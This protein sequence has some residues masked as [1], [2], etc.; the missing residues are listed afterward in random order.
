MRKRHI[1]FA[2]IVLPASLALSACGGSGE[3]A[4][5][6]VEA[7]TVATAPVADYAPL[8]LG[9][10]KGFF[11]D[12]GL[13]VEFA[14]GRVGTET[15]TAVLS[16]STDF[17]GVAVPPLLVAQ[18]QKLDVS[19]VSPSSVAP[20][21]SHDSSVQLLVDPSSGISSEKDLEGKTV[22]VNALKAQLELMTR[23]HL[24]S[25]GI[26]A[27]STKFVEVPF[28]EMPAALERG[29]VDAIAAV[30][31]FLSTA[32]EEG[33]TSIAEVDRALPPGAPI[34]AFFTSD[35]MAKS[36]PE[37]VQKFS[38][39]MTQ[40][41]EY[42]SQNPDEVRD[43]IS[44]YS[45]VPPEVSAKMLLPAYGSTLQREGMESTRDAMKRYGFL[46][47]DFDLNEI[48]WEQQ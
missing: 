44:E 13:S 36:D 31:P 15:I 26:D 30:E 25:A 46:Q 33:A 23:W 10:E 32:L 37:V 48:F 6:G 29:D 40:S 21:A 34:T 39:A 2:A 42:A 11:E 38:A 9:V 27:E 28:A 14:S 4:S 41:L 16:G 3:T 8:Y 45:E 20:E 19:V 35:R 47:N 1:G 7:I 12:Q 22:A 5:G 24:E 17:A 18:G 43:V